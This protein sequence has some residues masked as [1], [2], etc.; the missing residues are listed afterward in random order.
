VIVSLYFHL[1]NLPVLTQVLV[2]IFK[3][4]ICFEIIIPKLIIRIK[5]LLSLTGAKL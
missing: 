2:F 1:K 5:D 4:I 3:K